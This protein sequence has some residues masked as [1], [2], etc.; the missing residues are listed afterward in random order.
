MR[1]RLSGPLLLH[2][3]YRAIRRGRRGAMVR[4]KLG[5]VWRTSRDYGGGIGEGF[6]TVAMTGEACGGANA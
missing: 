2:F 6:L 3:G 1:L 5:G 4:R